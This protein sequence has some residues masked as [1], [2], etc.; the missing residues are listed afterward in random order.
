MHR[1][2]RRI[3]QH[4]MEPLPIKNDRRGEEHLGERQVVGEG[5]A[6]AFALVVTERP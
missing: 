1:I 3:P 2:P 5:A 4:R 6:L